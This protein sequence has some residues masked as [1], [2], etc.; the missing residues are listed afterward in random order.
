MDKVVENRIKG[1]RADW[2]KQLGAATA[3]RDSLNGRLTSIQIDQGV[4]LASTKRGLR[5]T[6]VADITARA[7]TVFRLV[8]GAAVAFEAGGKTRRYGA[9]AKP[10]RP[11]PGKKMKRG[12]FGELAALKKSGTELLRGAGVL[13]HV[14]L[15]GALFAFLAVFGRILAALFHGG[16]VR[17]TGFHAATALGLG[18]IHAGHEGGDRKDGEDGFDR[19]HGLNITVVVFLASASLRHG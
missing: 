17:G 10:V 12:Q 14:L 7:R 15:G 13:L 8:N 19:L 4:T 18:D 3:E 11:L 5:P 9:E 1:L 2:E 16:L 6:A